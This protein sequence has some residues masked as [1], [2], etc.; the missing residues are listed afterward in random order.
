MTWQRMLYFEHS[1]H[2]AILVREEHEELGILIQGVSATFTL[3]RNRQ[4][5]K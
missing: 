4:L 5:L 1:E 2:A 3:G